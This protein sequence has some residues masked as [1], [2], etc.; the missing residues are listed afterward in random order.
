MMLYE[1]GLEKEQTF[2]FLE[3]KWLS[4][5]S[6]APSST[7]KHQI[8]PGHRQYP[9]TEY[10]YT[11]LFLQKAGLWHRRVVFGTPLGAGH[12]PPLTGQLCFDPRAPPQNNITPQQG[13]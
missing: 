7:L 10:V 11:S 8:L 1:N 9:E 13:T 4:R 5:A 2:R 12:R 3:S 6:V